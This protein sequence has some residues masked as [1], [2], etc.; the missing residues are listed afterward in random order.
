MAKTNAERQSKWRRLN[1][2]LARKKNKEYVKKHRE[3]K[4]LIN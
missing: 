2:I 1:H 3:K 4:I